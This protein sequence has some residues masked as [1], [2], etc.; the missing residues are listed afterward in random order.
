[1]SDSTIEIAPHVRRD[2]EAMASAERAR[3]FEAVYLAIIAGPP[4]DLN[5]DQTAELSER[6]LTER[7][8]F[9]KGE[10]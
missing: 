7:D 8:K 6:L 5:L 9:A 2:L 4:E 1:M 10:K 3:V